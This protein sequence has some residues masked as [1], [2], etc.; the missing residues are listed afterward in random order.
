[1]ADFLETIADA[2]LRPSPVHGRGLFSLRERPLGEVL[3]I[4]EGEVV[5]H[6]EDLDFLLSHEWNALSADEILLRRDWTSYGFIN[7]ARPANLTIRLDDHSLRAARDIMAG[8][9]LTLDYTEHGM[10]EVYLN[11]AHGSYLG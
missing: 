4:L 2:Q 6:G 3:C 9:E 10:P 1:M 8:E 11:S 7:H 5:S